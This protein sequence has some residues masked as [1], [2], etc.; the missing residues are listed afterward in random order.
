MLETGI[1]RRNVQN[2]LVSLVRTGFLQR[3]GSGPASRYQLIF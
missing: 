3:F 1:A 2:A